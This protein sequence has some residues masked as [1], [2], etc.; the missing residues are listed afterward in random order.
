MFLYLSNAVQFLLHFP[1]STYDTVDVWT[2]DGVYPYN[3]LV[4]SYKH[5]SA[6]P[7]QWRFLYH[8]SNA[9]IPERLID[10]HSDFLCQEKIRRR[11]ESYNPDIIV[12]VHPTMN[13]TPL[14]STKR[15]SK[16]FGRHIPFFTV[17][18]DL[19]S[20]HCTWF[21][22]NV[23]KIYVASDQIRRLAKVRGR[24][25]DDNIIMSGLP[26]RHDFAVHAEAMGDRMSARGKE[27]QRKIRQELNLSPDKQM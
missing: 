4:R 5:L 2:L 22:E 20:G 11:I 6:H 17:V 14:I 10:L 13:R 26:I 3:A 23:D 15:I 1:N 25:P 18:T 12:S 7:Q 19:G 16:A 27:Y 24:V 9:R 21:Q 8:F